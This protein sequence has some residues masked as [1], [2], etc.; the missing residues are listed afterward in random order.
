MG[1]FGPASC[2]GRI[3]ELEHIPSWDTPRAALGELRTTMIFIPL[4]LVTLLVHLL[5]CE[6]M[7][8]EGSLVECEAKAGRVCDGA[9]FEVL[10]TDN[11]A[12]LPK[13]TKVCEKGK[14]TVKGEQKVGAD[15]PGQGGE[16]EWYGQLYCDGDIIVDLYSWAF[17][18]KCG[19]GR[20]Y[21]YSRSWQEVENDPR[22]Q[23]VINNFVQ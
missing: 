13:V 10:K 19:Q 23:K 9:V 20:M 21:I 15:P 22:F 8:L 7:V 3:L 16:C 1:E 14:L 18:K 2:E 5:T 11:P 6:R 17:L 4:F 12:N